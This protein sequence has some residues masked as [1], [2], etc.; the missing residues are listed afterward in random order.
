MV[1]LSKAKRLLAATFL[2][3]AACSLAST[4]A[5]AEKA[6][7]LVLQLAPSQNAST[8]GVPVWKAGSPV[9]V[10]VMAVNN[11]D[12]T[13]H[14][15]LTSPWF[16]WGMDLRDKAGNPV[17]ET[18]GFL[19]MKKERQSPLFAISR[20]ILATVKPHETSQDAIEIS[21]AYNLTKAGEYFLQVRREFP[22]VG[23]DP[24]ESNRLEL[25]IEP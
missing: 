6:H 14:Y 15:A 23:K 16:D 7:S 22:E 18:E 11:S 8:P 17:P 10:L 21:Y 12:R 25:K 9:F 19:R 3:V 1:K 4:D 24:V 13:V 2:C 20:N 5:G